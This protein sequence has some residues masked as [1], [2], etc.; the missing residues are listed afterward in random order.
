MS[1]RNFLINAKN[2]CQSIKT[3]EIPETNLTILEYFKIN[4]YIS[5][6]Y[7]LE[8]RLLE[9]KI[10]LSSEKL[11]EKHK[12]LDYISILLTFISQFILLLIVKSLFIL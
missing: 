9:K 7:I 8:Y 5:K 11:Y 1:L 4:T 3:V 12:I 2:F 6:C 10:R